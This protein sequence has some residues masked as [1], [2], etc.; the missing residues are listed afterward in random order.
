MNDVAET[1]MEGTMMFNRCSTPKI[2]LGAVPSFLFICGGN[3]SSQVP[4]P[5]HV[6]K[7]PSWN[8]VKTKNNGYTNEA[9]KTLKPNAI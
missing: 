7:G 5:K 4:I 1:L 3:A 9:C 8:I 6:K 2:V